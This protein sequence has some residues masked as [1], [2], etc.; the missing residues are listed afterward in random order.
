MLPETAHPQES[1]IA[2]E[3]IPADQKPKPSFAR[4]REARI[5]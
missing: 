5:L 4:E 1:I 3:Q 2:A